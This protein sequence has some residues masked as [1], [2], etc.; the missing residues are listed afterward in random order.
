MLGKPFSA[1]FRNMRWPFN[2][3]PLTIADRPMRAQMWRSKCACS[4]R[5]AASNH[6]APDLALADRPR[7]RAQLRRAS[8]ESTTARVAAVA[9]QSAMR[10]QMWRSKCACSDS[11]CC[12]KSY[13]ARDPAFANQPRRRAQLHRAWLDSATARVAA[14]ALQDA[15][16]VNCWI[17]A[18]PRARRPSA[19]RWQASRSPAPP[20]SPSHNRDRN[21]AP[22]D[23]PERGLRAWRSGCRT[24][25]GRSPTARRKARS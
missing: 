4:I 11:R 15:G 21:R 19:G 18:R 20:P 12:I 24:A 16:V 17:S 6:T 3:H 7:R 25:R 22:L 2:S 23:W 13:H 9:L 8:Q 5:G 10:A 14:V 1:F